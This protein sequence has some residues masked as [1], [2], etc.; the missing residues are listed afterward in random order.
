[1]C[2]TVIMKT[3]NLI[4]NLTLQEFK[5]NIKS[6]KDFPT[7]EEFIKWADKHRVCIV[8]A[9]NHLVYVMKTKN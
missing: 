6:V 7:L 2:N 3:D 5:E 8:S 1:M 4:T 9:F